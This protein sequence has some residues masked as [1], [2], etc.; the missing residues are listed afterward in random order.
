MAVRAAASPPIWT[1]PRHLLR[2]LSRS[3]TTFGLADLAELREELCDLLG[4][5]GVREGPDMNAGR[6]VLRFL[7]WVRR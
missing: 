6:H 1:K 7:D 2:P 3:M 4:G 5:G